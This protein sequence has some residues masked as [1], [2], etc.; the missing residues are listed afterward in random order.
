[1]LPRCTAAI[2]GRSWAGSTRDNPYELPSVDDL[3]VAAL[4]AASAMAAMQELQQ[5]DEDD[6]EVGELSPRKATA[7]VGCFLFCA[8]SCFRV[9]LQGLQT[10]PAV[11]LVVLSAPLDFII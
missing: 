4:A 10:H 7:T 11:P 8:R 1:M 9:H 2:T 5:V 3:E 6:E